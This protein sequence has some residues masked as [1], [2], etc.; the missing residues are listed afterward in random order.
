MKMLIKKWMS[1]L[2]SLEIL[3]MVQFLLML[4]FIAVLTIIIE[5]IAI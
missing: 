1:A 5:I 4:I 3:L 2:D